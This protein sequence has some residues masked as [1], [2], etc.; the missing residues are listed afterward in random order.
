MDKKLVK[1]VRDSKRRPYGK[2]V[3]VPVNSG[4][5]NIGWSMCHKDDA[6]NPVIADKIAVSRAL[7]K[8][9]PEDQLA[10]IPEKIVREIEEMHDRAQKY[11]K[12]MAPVHELTVFQDASYSDR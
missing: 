9:H 3:A 4:Q 10:T 12:D 1:F 8:K 5:W 2:V 7:S 6:F 11:F